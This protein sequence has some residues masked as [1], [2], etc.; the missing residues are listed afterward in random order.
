VFAQKNRVRTDIDVANPKTEEVAKPGTRVNKVKEDLAPSAELITATTYNF[1]AATGVSLED[2]SSGTTTLVAA[3]TDDNNSTIANLGFEFWY[4]GV[5]FTQFGVNGNGFLKLGSVS[6]G[7]SFSNSIG[8]T[9]NAPKIAPYW[10][11]LCVG[12]NGKVHFKTIGSAPNRKTIVEFQ[13]M[14]I[15]RGAGCAGVGN[16]TFQVWLFESTSGATTPGVIEFVYGAIPAANAVDGGYSVGLQS[17]AATNFASV[18]TSAGSVSYAAANNTQT[19]AIAATTAYIFTPNTPLAPT[20][21]SVTAITPTSLTLNWNDTSSNE[22]GFA[23]YRS[24][25]NINFS[26]VSQTAANATS[27]ADSGLTPSTNYFYHVFA[28]TEGAQSPA[29]ANFTTATAPPGNISCVN[30]G[31]NWSAAGTWSGGVPTAGDNVTIGSGCTVTI[32]TAAVGLN[33]TVQSGG[34][35]QYDAGAVVRTLTLGGNVTIDS[36]G[37]VQSNPGGGITTHVLSVA[38][39][40]TNNGTLDLST[41]GNTAAARLT[42]TGATNTTFGGTGAITNIRTITVNKGTS[43]ASIVEVNPTNFTVQGVNTDVAGFLTLTNGTFKISGTFTMTNRVFTTAIYTIGGTAGI[44]LNNPNFTVAG[45]ATGTTS[46]CNGLFRLTQGIYTI[47]L[48]AADGFDASV[49]TAVYIIEGGTLN[50]NGRFDPQGTVNYTQTGGTINTAIVGNSVSAFGSFE[51]FGT[52]STFNMS[53]G[54]INIIN[55]ATGSTKDD[56]SMTGQTQNITGGQ[57]VFGGPGAPAASTYA[58]PFGTSFLP[59][60][61]VSPGM[62]L[63]INNVAVFFRGTTIAN[64]GAITSTGTSARF[65]FANAT[66]PMTYGGAGTFGTLVAPFQSISSNSPALATLNGPIVTLRVNLFTA[67]FINSG[68]ITLGN[69][70]ASASV[71]Q[72]GSAGLVTPGGTF[73]VSPVHNQGTGGE[74]VLYAQESVMRTTGFEVNPTRILNTLIVSTTNNVTI[75]GGD[76]LVTTALTLTDGV[77]FTGNTNT[78]IYN[79]T[80]ANETRTN[81]YVDGTMGRNFTVIGSFNYFVGQNGFTPVLANI[82]ANARPADTEGLAPKLTVRSFDN[83]LGGF[84][85]SQSI[86]RNWQL[87]ETGNLTAD[88]SF[89]YLLAD[90]N[91]VESDYRVYRRNSNGTA[92]NLCAGGPCVNTGTHTV[93]VT[94]VTAF[95][96]WTAAE[97]ITPSAAMATISGRVLTST[98]MPIANVKVVLN[99]GGLEHPVIVNTGTLGYYNF[100]NLTVGQNYVVTVKAR[101]FFFSDPTHLITLQDNILDSDFVADPNGFRMK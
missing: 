74:I 22:F 9:G 60:F 80:Q 79:G 63:N 39:N 44:W 13:N 95:S 64:A 42:F 28:V 24:T 78:L 93:S 30:P 20:F 69:G 84:S 14:Q 68:Q 75:S 70:G 49:T 27:F 77:L 50:A 66:S 85:P 99:G 89:T 52:T 72:T 61:T 98:G 4:D 67:G 58:I 35:L 87:E 11:D 46:G 100:E 83:T 48:T 53:G 56:F 8:S 7:S 73:D 37:I 43:S 10:D 1:A 5:R 94:G 40:V 31:G 38:G 15:T 21:S 2:M 59:N 92:D 55:P 23:V 41:N 54:T 19:N 51:I 101:R 25:D 18:T 65:D 17:G 29:S 45:T 33:L 34:L 97:L 90:V 81:G 16:G 96:R 62:T 32:D 91:G 36:G 76:I 57:V 26:F 86:S 71:V 6:T 88:L 47:G 3:S 82:T 12:S